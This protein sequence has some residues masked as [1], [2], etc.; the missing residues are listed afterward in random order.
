MAASPKQFISQIESNKEYLRIA[1]IVVERTLAL[2]T[3]ETISIFADNA[4]G[5]IGAAVFLVAEGIAKQ[6]NFRIIEHSYGKRPIIGIPTEIK[7]LTEASDVVVYVLGDQYGEERAENGIRAYWMFEWALTK[8]LG[9]CTGMPGIT[10]QMFLNLVDIDYQKLKGR[11]TKIAKL[12]AGRYI[13][14]ITPAGTDLIFSLLKA[15]GTP[16]ETDPDIGENH[17]KGK[18]GVANIPCGEI[19]YMY[20]MNTNHCHGTVVID[21]AIG[22][23][24]LVDQPLSFDVYKGRIL[25]DTIKGGKAAQYLKNEIKRSK[26]GEGAVFS[27]LGIGLNEK[28]K[29]HPNLNCLEAEKIWGTVHVAFGRKVHND[30]VLKNPKVIALK[31]ETVKEQKESWKI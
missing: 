26:D 7:E 23:F 15:D 18:P 3:T 12:I 28:A 20:E 27:E 5:K 31:P 19:C 2:K 4:A 16:C 25:L 29:L 6:A 24:G 30:C 17:E 8:K 9:R 10:E 11:A 14:I 22:D 13:H 1:K 21:G